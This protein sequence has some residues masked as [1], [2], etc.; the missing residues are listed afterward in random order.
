MPPRCLEQ[1]LWPLDC[2]AT[3][4]H[5]KSAPR[6]NGIEQAG[7][8]TRPLR[9]R[10][11]AIRSAGRCGLPAAP[12]ACVSWNRSREAGQLGW[13][14]LSSVPLEPSSLVRTKGAH[15]VAPKMNPDEIDI[16]QTLVSGLIA[17]QFPDWAHLPIAKFSSAGTDNAIYR[18][19][20]A[21]AV[22]L[23][24]LGK[25]AETVAKEQ[26][27][28]PRLAPQLPLSIPVPLAAGIP[29]WSSPIPGRCIGGWLAKMWPPG[30][31]LTSAT[32][33]ASS[34]SS[35]PHSSAS[36]PLARQYHRGQL[37]STPVTTMSFASRS[38]S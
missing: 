29:E 22:R 14:L 23:P 38:D 13:C 25:A 18:L 1:S 10:F 20:D 31:L 33:P 17:S 4:T 15:V 7:H 2:P 27:W 28:L 37:R 35:S 30:R 24:R 5:V 26:R 32:W 34:A 3:R 6:P 11:A 16:S 8:L 19:G 12:S 9:P 36:R 21:M